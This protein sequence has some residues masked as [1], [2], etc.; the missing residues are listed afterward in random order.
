M[1]VDEHAH[2]VVDQARDELTLGISGS[3]AGPQAGA[4]SLRILVVAP[5]GPPVRSGVASVVGYLGEGLER[6]GHRIDVLAYPD[7]GR[8]SLGEIRL[9]S[10][11]FKLPR[12]L[13]RID[14]YDVI[15]IHGATPT[16][17]D[18]ALLFT[19]RRNR[20]S[21]VIYTHHMDVAFGSDNPLTGLYNRV[22]RRLA[23][24]ADA[25]VAT[26]HEN[27]GLLGD[28]G[29]GG[30]IE[31]GVDVDQFST[32]E[33]KDARFTV[34]FV[35]QF[36][37]YK[38]V[39]VLLETMRHIPEARLLLAGHGPEE[40]A[41]RLLAAE[42]GLDVEFH[43]GVDDQQLRQL[44]RRAHAIVLPAVSRREAFGLVLLEGMAAGCV[45]I[46][47]SLP[48]VREVVAQAGF[49]FPQG[50]A[51]RLE[52]ILRGLRETPALVQ[53][54]ASRARLRAG[55]F[56]RARTIG[57]YERLITGLI[58][59]RGLKDRIAD[60]RHSHASALHGFVADVATNLEADWAEMLLCPSQRELYTV[61]STEARMLADPEIRRASSLVSWYAVN[62][63]AST[64]VGPDD[65]PLHLGESVVVGG[66]PLAAMVAPLTMARRPFGALVLIRRERSFEQ[67]DLNNLT[68]FARS[69]APSLSACV[70]DK[71]PIQGEQNGHRGR[72][73]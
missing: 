66:K 30:V 17:S 35:G 42:L 53:Q 24:R 6:R 7:V 33:P 28:T 58:G 59:C 60:R 26:T 54:L 65:G 40:R 52:G 13:R 34:L 9:S 31:L 63:A 36:R 23:A 47:S 10:L 18:V 27:L 1:L 43:V 11:I 48:G 37:P 20:H 67:R 8:L 2:P 32:S 38:G 5:E 39:R 4:R 51:T 25:V 69:V 55:E 71:G 15:H 3:G 12:L 45:P 56:S 70:L 57:E 62:T 46:A 29:C 61:A 49:V 72:R 19:C 73:R 22:H 16:V 44:Y 68:C 14:D 50:D 41:Y 21:V 64:L